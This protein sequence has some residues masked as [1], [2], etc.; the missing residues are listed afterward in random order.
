M[1]N[2]RKFT[3]A[4]RAAFL[5][6]L[7]ACGVVSEAAR[8]IGLCP[9]GIYRWR[10]KDPGFRVA[11]DKA[12][13]EAAARRDAEACARAAACP[14]LP[15]RRALT[16]A[17]QARF[18]AVLRQSSNVAAAARAVGTA[19]SG[20][21]DMR[22][23]DPAFAAAWAEAIEEAT[24]KLEEEARRRALDGTEEPVFYQG[25]PVGFVRRYSDRLLT[26]LLRAYRPGRFRD[27]TSIEQKGRVELH[28][29]TGREVP[30]D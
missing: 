18:L 13:M 19:P 1:P 6:A 3:P 29:Y 10:I 14:P 30:E 4:K 26:F 27:S 11:W 25:K 24:D 23:R 28:L 12:L 2:H 8:R 16:R 9:A 15:S 20:W 22:R 5:D 17:K 21:Y 7:R